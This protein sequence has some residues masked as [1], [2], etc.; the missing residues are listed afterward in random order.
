MRSQ[1]MEINFPFPWFLPMGGLQN[2]TGGCCGFYTRWQ[3][4]LKTGRRL[5]AGKQVFKGGKE[6]IL[7]NQ[8][9]GGL[10]AVA[11]PAFCF[12]SQMRFGRPTLAWVESVD[13]KFMV[14][15]LFNANCLVL[16]PRYLMVNLDKNL[17]VFNIE[18]P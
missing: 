11:D 18:Y 7:W 17:S 6:P 1:W 12:R 8:N 13:S 3:S 4:L 10:W 16:F 14:S 2:R 5:T 15:I 9:G